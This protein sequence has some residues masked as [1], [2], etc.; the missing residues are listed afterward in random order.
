MEKKK[1]PNWNEKFMGDL[2]KENELPAEAKKII[3]DIIDERRLFRYTK[4]SYVNK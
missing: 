1:Y 3:N 2:S 4:W